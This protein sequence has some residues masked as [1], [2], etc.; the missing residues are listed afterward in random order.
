MSTSSINPDYGVL[1]SRLLVSN[2][3]KNTSPFLSK[4]MKGVVSTLSKSFLELVATHRKTLDDI[5]D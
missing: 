1:A 3:N 4:T 5:C 2:R